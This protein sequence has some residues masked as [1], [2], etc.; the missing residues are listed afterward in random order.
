[1][2]K[3]LTLKTVFLFGVTLG[4]TLWSYIF[5]ILDG[6]ENNGGGTDETRERERGGNDAP[7]LTK[8]LVFL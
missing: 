7:H 5:N 6:H 3:H 4:V 2:V 1:M 8:K